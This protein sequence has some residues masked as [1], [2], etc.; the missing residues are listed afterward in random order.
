MS[1]YDYVIV[2]AGFAGCVL[3]IHGE[4]SSSGHQDEPGS[5]NANILDRAG[6]GFQIRTFGLQ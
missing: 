2:G 5:L 3:A 4:G 1:S 6:R